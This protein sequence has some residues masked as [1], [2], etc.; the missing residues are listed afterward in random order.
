MFFCK[1]RMA[2]IT[3]MIENTPTSTPSSVSAERSLCAEMALRA[4]KQLSFNSA[5]HILFASQSVNWIH[6]RRAPRGEEARNHAGQQRH[7]D[8]DANNQQRH[9]RGQHATDQNCQ[10][11]G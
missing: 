9:V 2:V 11:P 10:R 3:T 8:R 5:R 7:E 6:P 1:M 4:I